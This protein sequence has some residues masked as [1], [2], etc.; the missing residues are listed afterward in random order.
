MELTEIQQSYKDIMVNEFIPEI[1]EINLKLHGLLNIEEIKSF[2]YSGEKSYKNHLL[3]S[4]CVVYSD[5][6]PVPYQPIYDEAHLER[7][8]KLISTYIVSQ[9][10]ELVISQYYHCSAND[11]MLRGSS[12]AVSKKLVLNLLFGREWIYNT[13]LCYDTDF[14]YGSQH[15]LMTLDTFVSAVAKRYEAEYMRYRIW[16]DRA[17]ESLRRF[18]FVFSQY[19][20]DDKEGAIYKVTDG[21]RELLTRDEF[22]ETVEELINEM[23]YHNHT[24][25]FYPYDSN[26]NFA[27]HLDFRDAD[28][29]Y[30][31]YLYGIYCKVNN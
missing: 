21:C 15:F 2:I 24:E 23:P 5:N 9:V 14:N 6:I 11:M 7:V 22:I 16:G 28:D 17:I 18:L 1:N 20:I 27:E 12:W 4:G 25:I 3:Y 29:K 8:K 10:T 26:I 30:I 19:H 13:D 31:D